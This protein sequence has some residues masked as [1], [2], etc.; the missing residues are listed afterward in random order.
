MN[1]PHSFTLAGLTIDIVKSDTLI[2][3]KGIIGQANYSEQKIYIDASHSPDDSIE[4]AFYHELTHFI[5]FVMN[6]DKLR[7]NEKFVD[8]FSHL[9][10]QALKT[11]KFE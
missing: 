3:E 7:N 9:L 10:Y 11:K 4:Q 5:L 2:K 1:I 6:E 8:V